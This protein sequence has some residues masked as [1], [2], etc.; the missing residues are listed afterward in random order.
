MDWT[1]L[2]D[3]FFDTTIEAQVHCEL[4]IND[5]VSISSTFYVQILHS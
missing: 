4:T 1:I 3:I 2:M 5:Q